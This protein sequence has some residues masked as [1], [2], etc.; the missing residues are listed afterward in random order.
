MT[1]A[2]CR[3]AYENGFRD[4]M[5]GKDSGAIYRNKKAAAL[6]DI[7]LALGQAAP[8][9]AAENDLIAAAARK[10]MEAVEFGSSKT[11]HLDTDRE[12]ASRKD[13][14]AAPCLT[15]RWVGL[16][17]EVA[18]TCSAFRLYA[19]D[20]SGKARYSLGDLGSVQFASRV[21]DKTWDR[22]FI[23]RCLEEDL[24]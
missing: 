22:S 18:G 19:D 21:P 20:T 23:H 17:R 9:T 16:C 1:A 24:A 2:R 10:R 14:R 8:M 6:Y 15:C 11:E 12:R 3:D 7:G 5:T 13:A 4:G